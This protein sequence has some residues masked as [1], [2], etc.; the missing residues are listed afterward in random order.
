MKLF[1]KVQ[2]SLKSKMVGWL[3]LH[4]HHK[5]IKHADVDLLDVHVGNLRSVRNF[6]SWWFT[7]FCI[8]FVVQY[9]TVYVYLAVDIPLVRLAM[10]HSLVNVVIIQFSIRDACI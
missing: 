3:L 2:A 7:L 6:L 10:K 5:N 4:I 8:L 1:C 9:L